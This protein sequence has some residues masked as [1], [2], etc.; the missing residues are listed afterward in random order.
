MTESL[1]KIFASENRAPVGTLAASGEDRITR[2]YHEDVWALHV[3]THV[4][5]GVNQHHWTVWAHVQQA[6]RLELR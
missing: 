3:Y 2:Q 1:G 6:V 4:Q 5:M